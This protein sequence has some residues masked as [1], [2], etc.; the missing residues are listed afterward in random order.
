MSDP[1]NR[2]QFVLASAAALG[3]APLLSACGG[4]SEPTA[5]SECPGYDVLTP[6][7]LQTRQALGYVDVTPQ[8]EKR[9]DNCR[10]YNRT[11]GACGG[12]Q[13]FQGPVLAQGYCNSWA[14]MV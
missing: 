4:G 7:Q 14:A 6:D 13:L 3:L 11:G 12:C 1:L 2:R 10:F 5:A 8:P 9:C